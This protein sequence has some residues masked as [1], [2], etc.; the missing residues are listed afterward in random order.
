VTTLFIENLVTLDVD[1]FSLQSSSLFWV[2][3]GHQIFFTGTTRQ[4]VSC[5]FL[6]QKK[7]LDIVIAGQL[8]VH[9]TTQIELPQSSVRAFLFRTWMTF[10]ARADARLV[11]LNFFF[12]G[13]N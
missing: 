10:R 1:V 4:K 3:T 7:C 13:E 12:P 2:V 11:K 9:H 6:K 5:T 8:L